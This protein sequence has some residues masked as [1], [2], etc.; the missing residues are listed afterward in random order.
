MFAKITQVGAVAMR[1]TRH[2]Q[3][4]GMVVPIGGAP[5]SGGTYCFVHNINSGSILQSGVKDEIRD[6]YLN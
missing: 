3:E 1:R 5:R 4:C 6:S 2:A